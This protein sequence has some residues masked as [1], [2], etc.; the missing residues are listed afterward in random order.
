MPQDKGIQ[1]AI[2]WYP[3]LHRY[4]RIHLKDDDKAYLLTKEILEHY[5]DNFSHISDKKLVK[6]KLRSCWM[7]VVTEYLN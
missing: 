4:F 7:K 1:L 2:A 5:Y 6:Q 3:I